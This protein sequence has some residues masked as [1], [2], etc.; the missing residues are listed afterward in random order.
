MSPPR[1]CAPRTP[2]ACDLCTLR[3]SLAAKIELIESFVQQYLG[4]LWPEKGFRYVQVV[5]RHVK[6]I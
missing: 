3:V 1:R 2:L 6:Q 5:T 4:V